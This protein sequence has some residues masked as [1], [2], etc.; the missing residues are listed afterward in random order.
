MAND[1]CRQCGAPMTVADNY[2]SECGTG[3]RE[4]IKFNHPVA[5]FSPERANQISPVTGDDVLAIKSVLN[6]R[7][8]VFGLIAV[9]GPFGLPALWFSPRFAKRTKIIA[10]IAYLLL[11]TVLPL[12]IAWYWLDY[13]MR[14]LV[15]VFGR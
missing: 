7:L 1:I 14:P 3:C 2:C 4:L 5:R 6:S 9:A 10:T 8:A 11:A 15:E 12:A 13:S